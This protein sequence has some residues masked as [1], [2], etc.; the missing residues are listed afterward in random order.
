MYMLKMIYIVLGE[1]KNPEVGEKGD[2]LQSIF[3]KYWEGN[4]M[5]GLNKT[6]TDLF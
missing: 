5:D 6:F 3:S 1:L 2:I 4:D